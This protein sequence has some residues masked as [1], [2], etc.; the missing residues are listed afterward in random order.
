M[1]FP[2]EFFLKIYDFQIIFA[3][4]L[5]LKFIQQK[6]LHTRTLLEPTSINLCFRNDFYLFQLSKFT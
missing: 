5:V 1:S 3:N 2:A 6:M 4:T